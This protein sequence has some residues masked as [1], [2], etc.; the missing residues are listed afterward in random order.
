MINHQKWINQ[1]I[2]SEV[3]DFIKLNT[4]EDI[5]LL[6]F[7]KNPFPEINYA[8]LIQQIDARKRAFKK[9][10]TWFNASQIIYPS[11][12]SLQ[13]TSSELTA[14]YK[15]SLING[16]Y[17]VDLTGGFGVD[18]YYFSKQFKSFVYLEKNE[19][20]ALITQ[21]NFNRLK[22]ENV[23]FFFLDS[24]DWLTNNKMAFDW[25]YL[26]PARRDN[27]QKKVFRFEDCEP[28]VLDHLDLYFKHSQN[29]LIKTSPLLDI[30]LAI[31]QLKFVKTIHLVSVNNELKELL[32]LLDKSEKVDIQI[33]LV[34]LAEDLNLQFKYNPQKIW[35]F[36]F[37]EP[38]KYLYLPHPTL[39]KI[40]QFDHL[41]NDDALF[42]LH[43]HS[44]LFTSEKLNES[45]FGK[46]FKMIKAIPFQK[47]EI[48][49][50]LFN[51]KLNISCRN[52]PLKPEELRAKFKI[53]D[54]GED[55]VFFTTNHKNEK[56]VLFCTKL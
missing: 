52:F 26:D 43:P 12:V 42:K 40:G 36:G 10:P 51:K 15:A 30:S 11:T 49:P 35:S 20:L 48:K 4:D 41:K 39:M 16:E 8:D 6:A 13:Q 31:D 21:H 56:I 45:F 1:L 32:F 55:Y 22:I 3:Q 24:N 38:L 50:H 7:K 28:Q 2:D 37:S 44:H 18:S 54:G 33:N 34:D 27:L 29:I 5:S 47:N 19:K 9:L 53:K 23:K 17:G 46:T 25:L 14:A